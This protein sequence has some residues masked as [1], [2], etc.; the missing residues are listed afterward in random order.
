[1]P[2]PISL[3]RL[4]LSSTRS[5]FRIAGPLATAALGCS[6]LFGCRPTAPAPPKSTP[7]YVRLPALLSL[8]PAWADL[9]D[10]D[11]LIAHTAG[12]GNSPARQ[13]AANAGVPLPEAP[14]PPPLDVGT[15]TLTS[16]PPSLAGVTRDAANRLDRL[17]ASL[18]ARAERI[19]ER[20]RKERMEKV[21]ADVATKRADL[22]AAAVNTPVE[23]LLSPSDRK[24]LRRL[25]FL[26]IAFESQVAVLFPPARGESEA[27]LKTVRAQIAAIEAKAPK[28]GEEL[29]ARVDKQVA[30]YQ[31]Q[32][33]AEMEKEL[34]AR[35]TALASETVQR[36]EPYR[37]QIHDRIALP[38]TPSIVGATGAIASLEPRI[39]T[40]A[41]VAGKTT[42]TAPLSAGAALAGLRDQRDRL[43]RSITDELR[44]RLQAV[45]AD[46]HW[47]LSYEPRAGYIDATDGAAS[48]LRSQF[49]SEAAAAGAGAGN[50]R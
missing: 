19:V 40:P 30:D 26:E 32:R 29:Q 1:M 14:M 24:D 22:Q 28:P 17:T 48:A 5:R 39:A 34:G 31:K 6:V 11:A 33:V 49:K 10:L 13:D 7:V 4:S 45:A 50:S 35:R 18:T 23:A 21:A 15:T 2:E 38:P 25:Q 3:R 47:T 20:E 27:K 36:L 43:L 8:H 37:K 12:L 44:T 16:R 9:R 42:A 46:H 41:E